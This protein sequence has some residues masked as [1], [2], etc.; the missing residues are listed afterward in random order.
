MSEGLD[1]GFTGPEGQIGRF[2]LIIGGNREMRDFGGERASISI[3]YRVAA[4][5]IAAQ[6]QG[7]VRV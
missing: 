2:V 3:G 7:L 1:P 6:R 4:E 5:C